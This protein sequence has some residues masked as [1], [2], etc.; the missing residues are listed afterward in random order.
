MSINWFMYIDRL[1]SI[2]QFFQLFPAD[3]FTDF[4][5]STEEEG[6]DIPLLKWMSKIIQIVHNV[7]LYATDYG[8]LAYFFLS[9]LVIFIAFVIYIWNTIAEALNNRDHYIC[10]LEV[11]GLIQTFLYDVFYI[12]ILESL[13]KVFTCT[14]T[15]HY[16]P[17]NPPDRA[18]PPH[19]IYSAISCASAAHAISFSLAVFCIGFYHF[20]ASY[21]I[22]QGSFYTSDTITTNMRYKYSELCVRVCTPLFHPIPPSLSFFFV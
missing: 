8:D 17:D 10:T 13:L 5:T 2:W 19:D 4:V 20:R 7:I 21:Y 6:F 12:Q 16:D 18:Y 1:L 11:P 15:C 14:Y 3:F 9:V 22:S